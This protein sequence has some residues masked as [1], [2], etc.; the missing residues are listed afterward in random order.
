M[1]EL[2]LRIKFTFEKMQNTRRAPLFLST[3]DFL[4]D[5]CINFLNLL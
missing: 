1:H 5:M 3:V 4:N 2:S